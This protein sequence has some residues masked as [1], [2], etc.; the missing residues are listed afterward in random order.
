MTIRM[1]SDLLQF[2][3]LAAFVVIAFGAAFFVLLR[4]DGVDGSVEGLQYSAAAASLAS[5]SLGR[6]F[7]GI[8]GRG[9]EF[10]G[11]GGAATLGGRG[12]A[13]EE[14]GRMLRSGGASV[15]P[16]SSLRGKGGAISFAEVRGPPRSAPR[17]QLSSHSSPLLTSHHITS[18]PLCR[19]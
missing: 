2:L 6:L 1:L 5:S 17:L 4:A 12:G 9:T 3:T 15:P 11:A 19:F 10:G 13:G 18:P 8:S 14:S 7:I 16:P